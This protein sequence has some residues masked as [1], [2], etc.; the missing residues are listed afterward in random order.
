MKFD[1]MLK[2]MENIVDKLTPPRSDT[3]AQVKNINFRRPQGPKNHPREQK[4]PKDQQVVRHAFLESYVDE[5]VIEEKYQ[6]IDCFDEN[7]M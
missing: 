5:D 1:V 4:G 6:Q 2:T 3:Q 7:E